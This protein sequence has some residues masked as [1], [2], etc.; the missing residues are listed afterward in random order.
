[1]TAFKFKN[2][3]N[4]LEEKIQEINVNESI[5]KDS[6]MPVGIQMPLRKG[7]GKNETLFKMNN[8]VFDQISNNL[9]VFLTTKKGELL[10]KPDFGTLLF[11][12]YNRTDL[13]LTDIENIA[14]QEISEGISKYFPFVTLIDFETN[15]IKSDKTLNANYFNID[16][17]YTIQ[18][19]EDNMNIISLKVRR[20]I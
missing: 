3:G 17:R 20:S 5:E 4:N 19:F 1:M 8:N 11:N 7:R 6:L 16:I 14:M 2:V 13:D 9:K 10:G 18:G 15:E 12:I